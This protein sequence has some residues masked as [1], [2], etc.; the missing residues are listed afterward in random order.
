VDQFNRD[1]AVDIA[2]EPAQGPVHIAPRKCNFYAS[3]WPPGVSFLRP[4]LSL[5]TVKAEVR[6][7]YASAEEVR[8]VSSSS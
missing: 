1:H 8:H 2:I 4:L 6:W 3:S 7:K 5:S